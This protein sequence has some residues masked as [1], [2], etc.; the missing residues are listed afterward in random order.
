MKNGKKTYLFLLPVLFLIGCT[1]DLTI[2][3]PVSGAV[4]SESSSIQL[5]AEIRGGESGCGGEDCNCANWWWTAGGVELGLDKNN[6][7]EVSFCRYSWIL[8]ASSLGAGDHTLTFHGDQSNYR[9]TT[10]SVD[11]TI[12]P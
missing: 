1:L 7:S 5:E 3:Q 10:E 9:E 4:F 2:H 6:D 12:A 11:I 8:P